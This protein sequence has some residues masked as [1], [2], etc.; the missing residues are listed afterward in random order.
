VANEPSTSLGF[1]E[2][3]GI[4]HEPEPEGATALGPYLHAFR[5]RRLLVIIVVLVVVV[6][7]GAWTQLHGRTY[8]TTARLLVNPLPQTDTTFLGLPLIR[9]TGDPSTTIQTAAALADSPQAQQ[10]A[11][12]L[13]GTGWSVHRVQ[14]QVS[15]QPEGQSNILDI[16]ASAPTAAGA[17]VLANTFAH[18]VV[19]SRAA[20]LKPLAVAAIATTRAQLA[21]IKN[22]VSAVAANLEDRLSQLQ[23][24]VGGRDPTLSFSAV[25][26]PPQAASG[27]PTALV[28]GLGALAG[29]VLGMGLALAIEFLKPRRVREEEEV[30]RL[31]L[32]PVLAR[33]P[34]MGR[35]VGRLG[36]TMGLNPPPTMRE[37]VR[38]LRIQLELIEGGGRSIMVTSGSQGDGKTTLVVAL[39]CALADAGRSVIM[40]DADFRKPDLG[41]A[42]GAMPRVDVERLLEP[43]GDLSKAL[44]EVPGRPSLRVLPAWAPED[45]LALERTT[46][47]LNALLHLALN[48]ADYVIV[49]TPPLGEVAD[50]LK[51]ALLIDDL[52]VVSRLGNSREASLENVR[53][54]LARAGRSP[55]GL[56]ING[57]SLDVPRGYYYGY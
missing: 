12:K 16:S 15:V 14:A 37:A 36:P 31:L 49:D 28:I 22:P 45:A 41:P 30:T 34:T 40:V 25:A 54:L 27:P 35:S 53:D 47:Q 24:V 11:A 55:T 51:A 33:I 21:G 46:P 5:A 43:G 23:A 29:L 56:V 26:V 42:L 13:M 38:S 7:A 17:A 52:I 2:G 19:A 8:Q 3:R 4:R 57:S 18:A 32:A 10:L 1:D 6:A 44:V 9:D 20:V 39:G 48:I 50:A